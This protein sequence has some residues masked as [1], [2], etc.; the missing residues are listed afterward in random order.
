MARPATFFVRLCALV[1]LGMAGPS[2]RAAG[3]DGT[4]VVLSDI[5]F[6]P[7]APKDQAT[8]RIGED[9]NQA[10][11]T[12]GLATFAR[13]MTRADFAIVPGDLLAHR[14]N[15]KAAASLGVDPSSPA[16]DGVSISGK[17]WE[18]MVKPVHECNKQAPPALCDL[19]HKCMTF[20][21]QKRP[22]RMSEVQGALDRLVEQLVRK[23]EDRL[24][25]LEW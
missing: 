23:P 8:S 20:N 6:N 19:I 16:V 3:D 25:A 12:S 14:F 11:L 9:T 7:F 2:V 21:A 10:L 5:H 18:Q 15:A 4:F 22:E 24:E 17:A 13:A 1:V